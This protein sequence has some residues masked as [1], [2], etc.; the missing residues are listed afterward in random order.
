MK[1]GESS[2]REDQRRY[3]RFSKVEAVYYS[4]I[5]GEETDLR[6]ITNKAKL[7]NLGTGGI[8]LITG[9]DLDP[10]QVLSIS[11]PVGK[12]PIAVSSLATVSWSR[13]LPVIRLYEIGLSYLLQ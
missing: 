1:P 7:K 6:R 2:H 12:P 5:T 3:R 13:R 11:M 10:G 8:C 4:R 9:E